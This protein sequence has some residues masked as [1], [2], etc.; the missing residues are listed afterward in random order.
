MTIPDVFKFMSDMRVNR[1]HVFK[2]PNE[3]KQLLRQ[4][5][6]KMYENANNRGLDLEG[7]IEL[8]L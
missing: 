8:M 3:F 6:V 7:F 1:H 2:N 4:I 5:N